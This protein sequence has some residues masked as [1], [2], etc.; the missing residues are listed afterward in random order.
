MGGLR[1]HALADGRE[2]E[3]PAGHGPVAE[4]GRLRGARGDPL[5]GH[6]KL[7]GRLPVAVHRREQGQGRDHG[8]TRAVDGRPRQQSRKKKKKTPPFLKKKKKKKK[9]K[10]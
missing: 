3:L 8:L 1:V 10:K 6:R 9:K 4:R 7:G 5:P 2:G